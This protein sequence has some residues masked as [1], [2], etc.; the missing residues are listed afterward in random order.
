MAAQLHVTG[1][2]PHGRTSI[3]LALAD[4]NGL[5]HT[6][7]SQFKASKVEAPVVREVLEP[8]HTKKETYLI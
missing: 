6:T 8:W 3:W 2:P 7:F 5:G 4:A 1:C